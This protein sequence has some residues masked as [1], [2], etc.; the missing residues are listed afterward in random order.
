M[1]GMRQQTLWMIGW[2]LLV[3]AAAVAA[4]KPL[5]IYLP[6]EVRLDSASVE[7]GRVGIL[8]GEPALVE[9]AQA[10]PLG[11]FA[12]EGQVLWVDRSTILSRLASHGIRA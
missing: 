8:L 1:N 9:K 11:T 12:V 3:A 2:T 5:R 6:Q 4:E 7:L 10:V